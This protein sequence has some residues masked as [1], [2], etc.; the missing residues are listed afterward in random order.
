MEIDILK[1]AGLTESQAKG[2]LALVEHGEST[3][4]ELAEY[5]GETRTNAYAIVDKLEKLGLAIKKDSNKTKYTAAH[6]S[7][8]E[9]LAEKR[10]KIMAK[11]EQEIKT[12]ISS[13]IDMFY[14][15]NE[16]P[17]VRTLEGIDGIKTAYA[18][19]LKERKDIYL[20]RTIHDSKLNVDREYWSKYRKNRAEL[21]INTYAITPVTEL[22]KSH[23]ENEDEQMLFHRTFLPNNSDYDAP[24][25]IDVYGDKVALIAF[26]ETEMATIINS[27][28]IAEAMR[29]I[30]QLLAK[31]IKQGQSAS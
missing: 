22:A 18:D 2:Y 4:A 13:L 8:I 21:G 24:V 27:P 23:L 9:N 28:P 12:N 17:G 1:K 6:P 29:Q 30:L 31:L 20:L 19:T 14:S 5:T 15:F 16:L 7:A 26:G 3:P 25:E 11:N 10:R